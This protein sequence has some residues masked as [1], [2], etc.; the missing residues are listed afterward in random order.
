MERISHG[1]YNKLLVYHNVVI[2][3]TSTHYCAPLHQSSVTRCPTNMTI[4]KVCHQT[5]RR[6]TSYNFQGVSVLVCRVCRL[7]R[8]WVFWFHDWELHPIQDNLCFGIE[9]LEVTR[10]TKPD[11]FLRWP[12]ISTSCHCTYMNC[13]HVTNKHATTFSKTLNIDASSLL[14][15]CLLTLIKSRKNGFSALRLLTVSHLYLS[16]WAAG[17][18]DCK[19][20]FN[21]W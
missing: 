4:W 11:H 1:R 19:T 21:F 20:N 5:T 12:Y 16:S 10:Y 9:L 18:S 14:G 2:C 17:P 6:C 7:L 8:A 13:S 3:I 15:M